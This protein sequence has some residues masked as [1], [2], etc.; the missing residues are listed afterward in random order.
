MTAADLKEK[1]D[2]MRGAGLASFAYKDSD[3]EISGVF[4]MQMPKPDVA[5]EVGEGPGGW[6]NLHKLG[7]TPSDP[8][9]ALDDIPELNEELDA[10]AAE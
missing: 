7:V 1:L 6:K 10:R 3:C 2:A 9:F 8:P 4:E 5:G